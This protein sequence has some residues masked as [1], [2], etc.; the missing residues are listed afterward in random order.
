MS[1]LAG[2]SETT[3]AIAGRYV[4]FHAG[5]ECGEDR[6]A[7]RATADG[8]VLTGEQTTW[9][10]HP[11]PSR[12]EYRA[13]LTREWRPLGLEIHWTVRERVLRA[14]HASES[15]QWRV[16]IEAEGQTREQH[17]DFPE[18]CEVDYGS[19]LFQAFLL[20]RK[21]FAE[22]GEHEFPALRIG[23][24]IMAVSPERM[25]IRCAQIGT[26]DGPAGPVRAKRYVV[27]LPPRPE[28]EGW[29]FWADEDGFVLESYEDAGTSRTW[30]RLV[31]M[32]TGG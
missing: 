18:V 22:G 5:R 9:P 16:R 13:P 23:P 26:F 30:M 15:G 7:I 24:P 28:D 21:D 4:I 12:Q 10:P 11:F 6:W 8:W 17:G 14:F 19:H 3:A 1:S 29:S 2:T 32:T 20:A 27:S 25:R 31:E